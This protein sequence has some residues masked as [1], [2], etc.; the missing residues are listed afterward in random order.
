MICLQCG[1][2]LPQ[3]AK[4]CGH[5]GAPVLAQAPPTPSPEAA[6]GE[7]NVFGSSLSGRLIVQSGMEEGREFDLSDLVHIGRTE[8]NEIVLDDPEV[9]RRHASISRRQADYILEDLGSSN[10]TFLNE[11]QIAEPSI[12]RDGDRVRVGS[13]TFIF[14]GVPVPEAKSPPSDDA[15]PPM[16]IGPLPAP[17]V[18]APTPPLPVAQKRSAGRPGGLI[19]LGVG[20]AILACAIVAVAIYFVLQG[21]GVDL[22][23]LGREQ[24]PPAM[25]TLVVTQ[26]P[27]PQVTVVVTSVPQATAT[28]TPT[29]TI[30]P[31][32]QPMTVRVAPDGS[33]A[34][35]SLEAAVEAVPP[36][37][38][39]MLD[40]GT[41]RLP[42]ELAIDKPLLLVGS[43]MDATFVVGTAGEQVVYVSGPGPFSAEGITFRY[44]GTTPAHVV[45]VDGA[46]ASFVRCRF[47]GGVWDESENKGGNGLLLLGTMTGSVRES[48]TEGNGLNGISVQDQSQPVLED[49]IVSNNTEIGIV[50]GDEAGGVARQNECS[51]NGLYGIGVSGQAQPTLERNVCRDNGG[52]GI[53]YSGHASG[54]AQ[55]NECTG[56][57][58]HGIAVT[59]EAQPALVSNVC[60]DNV[61]I[62]IRF[63]G[64]AGGSARQNQCLGNGLSGIVVTQDAQPTL[65]GNISQNNTENGIA[66][67]ENSGGVARQ[68]ECSGNGY[69]GIAVVGDAQP[70]LEGNVSQNNTQQGIAYFDR[71]GGL[72]R[73]NTCS[74]NLSSGIVVRGEAAPTL[75]ENVCIDNADVGIAF[76]GTQGGIAQRNRCSG[77]TWG[78]SV[79]APADPALVDNE[80]YDNVQFD[81]VLFVDIFDDPASGW[82]TASMES[83][84][85]RY[86]DG[87][88]RIRDQTEPSSS[89][90]TRPKRSFGDLILL[91]ES[92]LVDGTEDNWHGVYCRYVDSD[93]YYVA[94]YSADG[95]YTGHAKVNGERDDWV[96]ER[97][98]AIHQGVGQTNRIRLECVGSSIRFW[99][100]DTLLIDVTDDRL[101]E[102]D[103]ALNAES[104][105]G[106]FTEV[107][108]DNL[109]VI[110]P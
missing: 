63:S 104:E 9:S 51:G 96:K 45:T 40:T 84:E 50:Y 27:V 6:G 81:T 38:T 71:S 106:D 93:N 99:V 97:S 25:V 66:F 28:P 1:A 47:T 34:Y 29:P 82:G 110:A 86:E 102:G 12:L 5:C 49:N 37:S 67:F 36:G 39:I 76:T 7:W 109:K 20:L 105:A 100:N 16:M 48:R 23:F 72:A 87:E 61:Q 59:E 95:Y 52:I 78:L 18:E 90:L 79:K 43:G 107:A 24:Q 60:S 85:V 14:H 3:G 21:K 75:E 73:Q 68:N 44:E 54:V 56:N 98:D 70:T 88:L 19:V 55:E 2:E 46:E 69:A 103:I 42:G 30:T 41:Y 17:S 8:D 62:G 80:C 101:T 89:I 53:R 77:N 26:S 15:S 74:G 64:S 108:Y 57:S 92:R 33:G 22:P 32:P 83:G 11:Q 4:F 31:T 91:V 13:T 35:P 94:A 10:G 58:L 65:E